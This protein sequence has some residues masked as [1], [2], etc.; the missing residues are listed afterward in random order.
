MIISTLNRAA[1][2]KETPMTISINSSD[3][4]QPRAGSKTTCVTW[5]EGG[6]A[7]RVEKFDASDSR[8]VVNGCVLEKLLVAR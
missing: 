4:D 2:K 6:R 7:K 1:R 5:N 8:P 3:V